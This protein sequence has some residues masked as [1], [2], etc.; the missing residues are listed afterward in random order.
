MINYK[1]YMI[2]R[3]GN[4]PPFTTKLLLYFLKL[5]ET[6]GIPFEMKRLIAWESV[7][8]TVLLHCKL[9]GKVWITLVV[10]RV[11]YVKLLPAAILFFRCK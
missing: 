8:S 2:V 9:D 1:K 5:T 3:K 10:F 11:V 6:R 7:L 4:N